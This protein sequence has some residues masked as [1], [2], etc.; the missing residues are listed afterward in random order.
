[1]VW[2][3]ASAANTGPATGQTSPIGRS[4]GLAWGTLFPVPVAQ[5]ASW[6][7]GLFATEGGA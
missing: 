1:M 5:A 2:M 3:K 7:T 6:M 4:A